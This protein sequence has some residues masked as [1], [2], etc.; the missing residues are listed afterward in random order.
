MFY[1]MLFLFDSFC[2]VKVSKREE[3]QEA[4]GFLLLFGILFS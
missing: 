1:I 2:N 3:K 4:L